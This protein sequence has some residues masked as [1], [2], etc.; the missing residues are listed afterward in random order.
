[1]LTKELVSSMRKALKLTM[2]KNWKFSF[3]GYEV[4]A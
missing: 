1:M 4:L 2:P 3:R